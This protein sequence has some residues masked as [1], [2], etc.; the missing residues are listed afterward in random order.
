MGA[1]VVGCH[2][3]INLPELRGAEKLA[4]YD[5]KWLVEFSGH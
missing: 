1:H 4:R 3:V 2:F 5:V